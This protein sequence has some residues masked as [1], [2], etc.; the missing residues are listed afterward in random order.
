DD[1]SIFLGGRCSEGNYWSNYNGTDLDGDGIGD[2]Y[3]PWEGVDSYPLMNLYWNPGDIDHD[4]DIDIFDVVKCAIAYGSTPSDPNWN[5][6]CDIAEPYGIINIF[7]LVT[8]A[9]SY[10][11]EYTP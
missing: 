5:P 2:S 9:A 10:G 11:E 6:H 3:L 1:M 8:M 7:D 4:L